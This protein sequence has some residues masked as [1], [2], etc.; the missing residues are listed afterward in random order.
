VTG[1]LPVARH[2]FTVFTPTHDRAATLPRVYDSLRAQTFRDFEWLIVDDGSTDGTRTLVARWQAEA[3]FPIRCL[4]QENQGKHVAFNR[5]V[6]EARGALFLTLDSDDACVPHALERFKHHWDGIPEAERPGFS[7]VTALCV[8][9]HGRLVGDRFPRDVFD[10]DS[11]RIHYRH[12]VR[13]EKWGFQRTDVLLRFPFPVPQERSLV[14]ESIV[15][16]AIA[17]RYRTRFVNEALRIYFCDER[18]ASDQVSRADPARH[19]VGYA[20]WHRAILDE[21]IDFL[22]YAPL[23][24]LR[25]AAHYSRFSLHAGIPLREQGRRLAGARGRLLWAAMLPVGVAAWL[26]DRLA[27]GPAVR[28]GGAAGRG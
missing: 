28:A 15:W 10:S 11:L 25:S 17:R 4:R 21:E 1:G 8:D 9:Q 2:T 26:R 7:A 27:S 5:G 18:P 6:R 12:R 3:A 23:D 19:A 20:L 16:N 13:G 22:R 24:F 14:P